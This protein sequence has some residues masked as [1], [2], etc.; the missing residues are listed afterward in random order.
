MWASASSLQYRSSILLLLVLD[1]YPITFTRYSS[2]LYTHGIPVKQHY[3]ALMSQVIPL[4]SPSMVP[5]WVWWYSCIAQYDACASEVIPLYNPSMVP[6]WVWWYHCIAPVW[7]PYEWGDTI[8]QPQYGALMSVV[9][10][11]YS[12]SMV[13]LW[14]WW[15]HCIA[16]VWCLYECGATIV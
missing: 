3:G 5:L 16:P 13:S 1:V 9:I 11:L 12:P 15:Y 6:L 8:V 14:V 10:P 4:Y 2:F 7:C